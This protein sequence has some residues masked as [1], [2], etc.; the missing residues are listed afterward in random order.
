[1]VFIIY[2]SDERQEDGTISCAT[3]DA[4]RE[5]SSHEVQ[6]AAEEAITTAEAKAAAVKAKGYENIAKEKRFFGIQ[7]IAS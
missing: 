5:T 1:M 4:K 6:N 7:F 2:G 3:T